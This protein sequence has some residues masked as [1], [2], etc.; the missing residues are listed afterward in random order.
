MVNKEFDVAVWMEG[1]RWA[2]VGPFE[3]RD[4]AAE[5]ASHYAPEDVA[6]VESTDFEP[7]YRSSCARSEDDGSGEAGGDMVSV[8]DRDPPTRWVAFPPDAE[9]PDDATLT[10]WRLRGPGKCAGCG[11][12]H[13]YRLAWDRAVGEGEKLLFDS[14][15][16]MRRWLVEW[17]EDMHRYAAF[18]MAS[19]EAPLQRHGVLSYEEAVEFLAGSFDPEGS[20]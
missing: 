20:G 6:V 3:S 19:G 5:Y 8:E 9:G 2:F 10:V 14:R 13:P 17:L 15:A 12:L 16:E 4:E 11:R 18:S 7:R 1:S